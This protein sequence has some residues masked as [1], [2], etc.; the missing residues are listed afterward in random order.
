M[1]VVTMALRRYTLVTVHLAWTLSTF[2][3]GVFGGSW[4]VGSW[5]LIQFPLWDWRP[6]H[7]LQSIAYVSGNYHKCIHIRPLRKRQDAHQNIVNKTC[8]IEAEAS[9]YLNQATISVIRH[10]H[11]SVERS[12]IPPTPMVL[13]DCRAA[14]AKTDVQ[15]L[16]HPG[17]RTCHSQLNVKET[18]Q[19][20]EKGR[21]CEV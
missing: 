14:D 13:N 11:G 19:F 20:P 7:H 6:T 10:L 12:S 18:A 8:H 9:T 1:S 15:F 2:F 3:P 21:N 16:V 5:S 17:S 4:A